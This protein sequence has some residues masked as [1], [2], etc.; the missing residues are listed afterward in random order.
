MRVKALYIVVLI[1]RCYC[2]HTPVEATSTAVQR[3]MESTI[4]FQQLRGTDFG[5]PA[6]RPGLV[7]QGFP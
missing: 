1:K 2:S 3:A 7:T 6:Y 5:H 4:P